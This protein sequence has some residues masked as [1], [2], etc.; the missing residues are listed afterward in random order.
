MSV[1]TTDT[2]SG[3]YSTNGATTA[4]P[5]TFKAMATDEVSVEIDGDVVSSGLYDVALD[6]DGGGT[7][8]FSTAPTTGSTLY[9]V[10]DPDFTQSIE[11]EN[12][13][14]WLAEPVNNANDRA[15]V[16]DL[17]LKGMLDR[18]LQFP[19]SETVT[20]PGFTFDELN[21]MVAA[22]FVAGFEQFAENISFQQAGTSAVV[23]DAQSRFR[24]TVS[25]KDFGAVGDGTTDDT[26]AIQAAIT[27]CRTLSALRANGITDP[28]SPYFAK[29]AALLFPA[30]VYRTTAPLWFGV[31]SG[32]GGWN[33]SNI[34]ENV[35]GYGAIIK[36][37]TS[38]KPVIDMAG[39]FGMKIEGL[40]I[41]GGAANTPNVGIFLARTGNITDNASAGA[42]RFT[43]VN[44]HGD[45]TLACLYNYAS[46]INLFT[47]C[48]FYQNSGKYVYFATNNN[49]RHAVTSDHA[50][51]ATSVQSAYGD[52]VVNSFF[53]S[54]TGNATANG[55]VMWLESLDFG[56]KISG[57]Y[58]DSSGAVA[59]PNIVLC[60]AQ[61]LTSGSTSSF[62]QGV[63]ISNVTF[64]YRDIQDIISVRADHNVLG[65]TI[66]GCS[67]PAN[68]AGGKFHLNVASTGKVRGLEAQSGDGGTFGDPFVIGGA[69]EVFDRRVGVTEMRASLVGTGWQWVEGALTKDGAF[70]MLDLTAYGVPTTAKFVAVKVAA[71]T[72]AAADANSML[73]RANGV[74]NVAQYMEVTPPVSGIAIQQEGLVP[75][76]G[77]KIDYSVPAN[78]GTARILL[79]E[80]HL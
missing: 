18:T 35:I 47:S 67:L 12:G 51:I 76:V 16:R 21:A 62:N 13:S 80:Y 77:G 57:G 44:V 55:A 54:S 74:A 71:K 56:P 6:A 49:A 26:T 8:T 42:H 66:S 52:F 30:G 64:E 5:F 29:A 60:N 72:S 37:E 10:S 48:V 15:A 3:P 22:G 63:S 68:T 20:A 24:D 27:Y 33:A 19:I 78:F 58:I 65:L 14:R 25:V 34:V 40:T 28:G 79:R 43:N 61:G 70:H 32:V 2:Y 31:D 73:L 41:Y 53:K 23:R 69:G 7:V 11:F 75:V 17:A 1:D 9:V 59:M 45:F 46:E 38:G 39:A 50:T 36:G 4:F